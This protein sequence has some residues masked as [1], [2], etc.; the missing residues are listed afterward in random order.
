MKLDRKNLE[1]LGRAVIASHSYDATARAAE[2]CVIIAGALSLAS[3][4]S[5]R[6]CHSITDSWGIRWD[7]MA[8]Q[9]TIALVSLDGETPMACT[10]GR[11]GEMTSPTMSAKALANVPDSIKR[12]FRKLRY[13][14]LH[15]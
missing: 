4:P 11:R 10:I 1:N 6:G 8:D 13:S 7:V 12:L 15:A 2:H 14:L 3:L 9:T 5:D